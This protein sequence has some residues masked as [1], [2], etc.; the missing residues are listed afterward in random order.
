MECLGPQWYIQSALAEAGKKRGMQEGWRLDGVE[1]WVR[2]EE[3]LAF[4]YPERITGRALDGWSPR[5]YMGLRD[6]RIKRG[7]RDEYRSGGMGRGER[8]GIVSRMSSGCGGKEARGEEQKR[9]CMHL[10]KNG[11]HRAETFSAA[12]NKCV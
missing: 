12:L 10:F 7:E 6:G 9:E 4:Q 2:E 1:V 11:V 5:S 3:G 8:C